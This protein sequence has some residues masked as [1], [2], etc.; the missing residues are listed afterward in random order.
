MASTISNKIASGGRLKKLRYGLFAFLFWTAVW[1]LLALAIG[2]ELFLP[3]PH[4]VVVAWGRLL[5][6]AFFWQAVGGSLL[7]IMAGFLLGAL[8]GTL[9]S[10]AAHRWEAVAAVVRPMILVL[11]STPVA[12]FIILVYVLIRLADL[13]LISVSIV[14][15]TVM[16]TPLF[17]NNLTE[18]YNAFRPELAEVAAVYRFSFGKKAKVLWWPQLRPYVSAALTSS[19]GLAWKAGISAEVICSLKNTIGRHLADAK[20]NLDIDLLFAWTITVVFLSMLLEALFRRLSH[21]RKKPTSVRREEPS[22]QEE[23]AL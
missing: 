10:L 14:I 15:V 11:R 13:P 23:G 19:L 3:Y 22:H 16:V 7:S 5:G 18:G 1:Y 8:F 12:S 4:T 21:R 9:L 20:S 6:Q 2:N 17:F